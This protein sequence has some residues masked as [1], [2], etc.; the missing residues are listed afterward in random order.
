MPRPVCPSPLCQALE[1]LEQR[2]LMSQTTDPVVDVQVAGGTA[3]NPVGIHRGAPESANQPGNVSGFV[4]LDEDADGKIDNHEGGLFNQLVFLDADDDGVL[5]DGERVS[6]TNPNGYY[7]FDDVDPGTYS[8]RHVRWAKLESSKPSSQRYRI[9]ISD[10]DES[11]IAD[12]NF[13][14]YLPRPVVIDYLVAYTT[15]ARGGAGGKG[16][17]RDEIRDMI[18]VSNAA[19]VNSQI[20]LRLNL[21]ATREVNYDESQDGMLDRDRLRAKGEGFIREIHTMRNELGADMSTLIGENIGPGLLGISYFPDLDATD[22]TSFGFNVV[23]R[24]LAVTEMV[25]THELGHNLGAGHA[26][27]DGGHFSYSHGHYITVGDNNYHSIMAYERGD[28]FNDTVLPFFSNPDLSYKGQPLGTNDFANNARTI[29]QFD[30]VV[31][32]YR[33]RDQAGQSRADAYRFGTVRAD[34]VQ[35][36]RDA[37]GQTDPLDVFRL[38]ITEPT[39]LTSRLFH[40]HRNADL[41]LLRGGSRVIET[42]RRGGNSNE[43]IERD[44]DPG[45]YYLRV[46]AGSGK[47]G[48]TYTLKLVAEA[49]E[50]EVNAAAA[51]AAAARFALGGNSPASSSSLFK[52]DDDADGADE[53]KLA[54][55]ERMLFA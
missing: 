42:S 32:G 17:I 14:V 30:D 55:L 34:D 11:A 24:G 12:R 52:T 54:S 49:A 6:Q 22:P 47:L 48:T 2:L 31:A 10:G 3:L 15:E 18:S 41:Q 51:A 26:H 40:L 45:T 29:R 13:G 39:H 19:F 25:F 1:P 27:D 33:D 23:R 7:V 36:I 53:D 50:V 20:N 37:V 21:V 38:K 44:L 35:V 9:R 43:R 4:W 16:A 28:V 5:D 46:H 8:L